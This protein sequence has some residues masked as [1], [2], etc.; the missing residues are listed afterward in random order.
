MNIS[1]E[2]PNRQAIIEE[3]IS[4]INSLGTNLE[5][6]QVVKDLKQGNLNSAKDWFN[7]AYAIAVEN[8]PEA[9]LAKPEVKKGYE[10][11]KLLQKI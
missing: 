3:A 2:I 6:Q 10:I 8:T 11:Y 4:F 9:S 1:P 7:R 5:V